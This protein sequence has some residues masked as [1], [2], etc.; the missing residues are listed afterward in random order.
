ME[1]RGWDVLL[2]GEGVA[3]GRISAGGVRA[4]GSVRSVEQGVGVV[5]EVSEEGP[6][7]GDQERASVMDSGWSWY[8]PERSA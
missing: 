1:Q 6:D 3:V 8:L 7:S 5:C 4:R 2:Q